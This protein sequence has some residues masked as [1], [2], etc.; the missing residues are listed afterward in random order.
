MENYYLC[1]PHA[2]QAASEALPAAFEALPAASEASCFYAGSHRFLGDHP[3]PVLN[4]H[5]E[6]LLPQ[7]YLD[8]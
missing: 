8:R 1:N 3:T 7:Y 5:V 2:L 6:E 4:T